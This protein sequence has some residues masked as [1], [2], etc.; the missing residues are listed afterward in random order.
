M[1][2]ISLLAKLYKET[3]IRNSKI[4]DSVIADNAIVQNS[5]IDDKV[6]IGRRSFVRYS[7]LGYGSYIGHDTVATFCNIGKFCSI[8]WGVSI[9]GGGGHNSNNLSTYTNYWWKRTFGVNIDLETDAYQ[10]TIIGNDVWIGCN[11][12]ILEGLTIGDGAIIGAGSV[13]TKSVEPYSIVAGNPAKLIRMRFSS[14]IITRLLDLK[15]WD[16]NPTIISNNIELF[17]G[18]ISKDVIDKINHIKNGY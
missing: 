12:V 4:G 5:I 10:K 2:E 11:S 15:W 9:V 1:N 6:E 8:S 13:V 3:D 18:E 14:D 17:I 7:S 16:I